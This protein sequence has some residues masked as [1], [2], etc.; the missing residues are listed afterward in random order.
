MLRSTSSTRSAH[1][2][3]EVVHRIILEM[4]D[5]QNAD[6]PELHI[7]V[8]EDMAEELGHFQLFLGEGVV[9]KRLADRDISTIDLSEERSAC[10]EDVGAETIKNSAKMAYEHV[11]ARR[12]RERWVPQSQR[13]IER[14]AKPRK[15]ILP[16]KRVEKNHFIPQWFV[17]DNWAAKDE[18]TIWSRNGDE[19]TPR[20]RAFSKWAYRERLYSDRLEA[21]LSLLEGDAKVPVQRLLA[22]RPLNQPQR[23]SWVGFLVVQI[24]RSPFFIEQT[25]QHYPDLARAHSLEEG[26][27]AAAEFYDALYRNNE[28]YN[29]FYKPIM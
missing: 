1:I 6:D 27:E 25:K 23:L 21:Y 19:F 11:W 12:I 9:K 10:L 17:R 8:R 29:I 22:R 24:I 5:L 7:N 2:W 14:E 3:D 26:P 13:A 15:T 16:V 20:T 18:I 4:F 28:F